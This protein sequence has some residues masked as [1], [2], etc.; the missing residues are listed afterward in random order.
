M[1]SEVDIKF[2]GGRELQ[3][4]L[5]RIPSTIENKIARSALRIAAK[6]YVKELQ[7]ELPVDDKTY[8]YINGTRVPNVHLKKSVKITRPREMRRT[9]ALRIGVSGPARRYAHIVEFGNSENTAQPVWRPVFHKK[10]QAVIVKF[11]EKLGENLIKEVRKGSH[12]GFRKF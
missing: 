3:K 4:A 1:S 10:A 5:N 6:V 7:K 8:M 11:A 9:L 2:V 12:K